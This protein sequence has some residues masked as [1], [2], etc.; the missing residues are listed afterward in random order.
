M[1]KYDLPRDQENLEEEFKRQPI[2]Q[3]EEEEEQRRSGMH[4]V[5]APIQEEYS[6][7]PEKV[8][9]MPPMDPQKM[10]YMPVQH[11]VHFFIFSSSKIGRT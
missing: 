11:F 6:E 7:S 8:P 10:Q 3:E 1:Q 9:E 2:R 4:Y 5:Q